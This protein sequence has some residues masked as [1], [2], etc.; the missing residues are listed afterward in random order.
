MGQIA[1]PWHTVHE[2]AVLLGFPTHPLI[3]LHTPANLK[4]GQIATPWH[5][6]HERAVL[7]GFPRQP[8]SAL[9]TPTNLKM[10]QIVYFAY[11]KVHLN[12]RCTP[13]NFAK[14]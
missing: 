8:L 3:A 12:R 11:Y 6:A 9:H 2:R 7:L 1:T 5:T 4:I 10:S 13:Q 14:K